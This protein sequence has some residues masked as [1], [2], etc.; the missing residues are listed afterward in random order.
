MFYKFVSFV[1]FDRIYWSSLLLKIK[2]NLFVSNMSIG[3]VFVFGMSFGGGKMGSTAI[4]K[5]FYIIFGIIR[6]NKGDPS[7]KQ[8]FVLTS[9]NQVAKSSSIMKSNPNI[10]KQNSLFL[11]SISIQVDFMASEALF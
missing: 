7:S 4:L 5:A 2:V 8:G 9:I 10:S 6:A 3:N 1:K 11:A